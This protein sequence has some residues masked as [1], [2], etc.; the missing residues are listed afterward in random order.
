M[1]PD[2]LILITGILTTSVTWKSEFFKGI[3]YSVIQHLLRVNKFYGA[4]LSVELEFRLLKNLLAVVVE[5]SCG[6]SS[7]CRG[8]LPP[9]L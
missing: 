3:F 1:G 8:A 4:I 5:C 6:F 9:R 7:L 2:I